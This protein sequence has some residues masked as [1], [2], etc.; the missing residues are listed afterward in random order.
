L[1]VDTDAFEKRHKIE[2]SELDSSTTYPSRSKSSAKS[3]QFALEGTAEISLDE[4]SG[5]KPPAN[6]LHASG[7]N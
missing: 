1:S 2:V 5:A 7:A 6:I 3:F 4:V